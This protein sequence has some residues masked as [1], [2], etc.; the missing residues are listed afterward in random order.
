MQRKTW[1]YTIPLRYQSVILLLIIGAL[2]LSACAASSPASA[3]ETP[4]NVT[5]E[6]ERSPLTQAGACEGK[7]VRQNLPVTNGVRVREIMTYLSNGSGVAAGDLDKDGDIDLV[8]ASVD[9]ESTIAWN[10][11]IPGKI[12]FSY[13][14]LEDSFVRAVNIVDVDGDGWLDITFTHRGLDS[15]SYW[16]NLGPSPSGVQFARTPLEGVDHYAYAMAWTDMNGDGA[17][18][19]V[20]GAYDIDLKGS[21]VPDEEIKAKGGVVVY[22]QRDGQ[23]I[24]TQLSQQAE[25][26]AI[27]LIDL[28]GD[29]TRDVWAANDF[30]VPDRIFLHKDGQWQEAE[31]FRQTS[32]SSMSIDWGD[33]RNNGQV[34]LFTT[35]MNPPDTSPQILAAWLPVLSKLEEKHGY[36]DPQIMAN[37]LQVQTRPYSWRNEAAQSG[38]DSTGWSW[39][40]KFGDFDNDGYLDLYI[41]NGMIAEN[42][43]SHLPDGELVERNQAFRNQGNG[44]FRPAPEWN[45]ASTASGRSMVIADLDGD[46]DLDIV[47]NNLRAQA[48]LFENRLCAGSALEVDLL[49]PSSHNQFALGTVLE[50]Y[51]S[52]GVLRRDTRSASGY[53]S[54]DPSRVHFGFPAGTELTKLIIHYPDGAVAWVEDLTGQSLLRVT[55]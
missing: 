54:G 32:Y 40:G 23:F 10:Q 20:T 2:L 48:E 12:D 35:D 38:I 1:S 4:A 34:A 25:S 55:R 33:L 43:F 52:Q 17:L 24:P 50:L 47:V 13:E 49:W 28:D 53:L 14:P 41:V 21:G 42:L 26:L 31:P 9:R 6:V 11:S 3:T 7:F 16:R 45:L 19:L 15:V 5:V 18:D 27:A 30:A 46:G 36:N 22:E 39:S 29:G 8:F 37:T 44:V 51:T